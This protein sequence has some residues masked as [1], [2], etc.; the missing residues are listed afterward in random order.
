VR[1][2]LWLY[3]YAYVPLAW[4]FNNFIKIL[5]TLLYFSLFDEQRADQFKWILKGLI[6]GIKGEHRAA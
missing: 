6:D 1:N 3:R 4:K 2:S 5:F